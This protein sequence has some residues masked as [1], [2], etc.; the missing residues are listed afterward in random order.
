MSYYYV[1]KAEDDRTAILSWWAGL[2]EDRP[3]KAEL[4]RAGS[5][6]EVFL[7]DGFHNLF[8]KLKNSNASKEDLLPGLAAVAGILSS[9]EE[10]SEKS[11]AES[12]AQDTKGSGSPI[13]SELRFSA[14]QKSHTLDEL[15][16]R[17][18]RIIQQLGRTANV[19]SA[20]DDVLHWYREMILH[21]E[22]PDTRNHILVRWGM[23]YF[24]NEPQQKKAQK[25]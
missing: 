18:R 21:A 20:A 17:M 24:Q 13:V 2:K 1:L 16:T 19:L 12:C 8:A 6:A 9:I 10:N 14:M 23:E 3:A 4:R 7:T 11:F 22:D 25:A 5:P 15:Y